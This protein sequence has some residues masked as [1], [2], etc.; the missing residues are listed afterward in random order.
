MVVN[1]QYGKIYLI[2]SKNNKLLYVGSTA[3]RHLSQRIQNHLNKKKLG[4]KIYSSFKV[5]DCDDYQYTLLK[6]YPCNNKQQ[7]VREEGYWILHYKDRDD[8]REDNKEQIA[9]K[10]KEC[11]EANREQIAAK[12]KAYNK[13][14]HEANKEQ[15][16]EKAKEYYEANNSKHQCPCGGKYI[17]A[18]KAQHEKTN[19]HLEYLKSH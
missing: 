14:Y 1:Y 15:K 18:N 12:A 5:L 11:V 6:E 17:K 10:R 13:E 19:R 16:I 8:Y 7:L 9:A 4:K 2:T 3:Q